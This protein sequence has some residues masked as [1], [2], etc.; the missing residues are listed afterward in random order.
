MENTI[1]GFDL[2]EFEKLYNKAIK[3]KEVEF[4]YKDKPIIVDY[5]KYLIE[6]L[7]DK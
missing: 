4:I 3:D 5:A 1:I 6:F 7:K 2:N